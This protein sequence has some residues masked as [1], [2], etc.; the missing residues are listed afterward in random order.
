LR[1]VPRKGEKIMAKKRSIFGLAALVLF[2]AA[3]FLNAVP[4][5]GPAFRTVHLFNLKSTQEETRLLAVLD[6]FNKLFSKLGY[7]Q[8]SYRF[9]KVQGEEPGHSTYLYDS[10]WPD[11]ST[12]DKVHQNSAYK[13]LLDKHL[14]FLQQVLKNEIYSKYLELRS[15]GQKE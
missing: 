13:K 14:P 3:S 4:P 1:K 12:Y 8:V 2:L 5:S 6:E 7:S 15:G 9:W 10:T 11:R